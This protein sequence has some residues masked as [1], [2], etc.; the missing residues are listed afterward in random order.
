[1]RRGSVGGWDG[2]RK[3]TVGQGGMKRSREADRWVNRQVRES[4]T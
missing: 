2:S 1:M 4:M 3:I